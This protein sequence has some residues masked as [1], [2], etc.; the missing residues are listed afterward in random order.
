M[1]SE[2]AGSLVPGLQVC[3]SP[4]GSLPPLVN[5]GVFPLKVVLLSSSSCLLCFSWSDAA[6]LK[7]WKA[8]AGQ[9][10]NVPLDDGG[11]DWETDPDF[12]V[13]VL[14]SSI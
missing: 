1:S 3:R 14:T 13:S 11:E 10:V 6:S 2:V 12:E 5:E 4:V 9:T 7:M 8:S